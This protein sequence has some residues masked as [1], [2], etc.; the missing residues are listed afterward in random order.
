MSLSIVFSIYHQSIINIIS[1]K[2]WVS[3]DFF[4]TLNYHIGFFVRRFPHFSK[5]ASRL[6]YHPRESGDPSIIT[7]WIPAF[8]GM[9]RSVP[10]H[11]NL[12]ARHW[13]LPQRSRAEPGS[14]LLPHQYSPR[15]NI[16]SPE[17]ACAYERSVS[18]GGV[19][20]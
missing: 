15:L 14:I 5:T 10:P 11:L 19:S 4:S 13:P 2:I 16:L 18:A 17:G 12:T 9:T 6:S 20:R 7:Y 1:W 3:T 8:A